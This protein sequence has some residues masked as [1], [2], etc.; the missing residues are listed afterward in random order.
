MRWGESA[1]PPI[2]HLKQTLVSEELKLE[3]PMANRFPLTYHGVKLRR[4][5]LQH[6]IQQ[7]HRRIQHQYRR[8]LLHK[9]LLYRTP[10]KI[11]HKPSLHVIEY[12]RAYRT[13]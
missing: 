7:H 5:S 10:T 1:P 3:K 9:P 11:N 13:R 2:L 12:V 8:C 4:E 6:R